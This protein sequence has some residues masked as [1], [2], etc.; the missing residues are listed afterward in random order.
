M[1]RKFL[2]QRLSAGADY[3]RP[4]SMSVTSLDLDRLPEIPCWDFPDTDT[5]ESVLVLPNTRRRISGA[6]GGTIKLKKRLS[7]VPEL[8]LHDLDQLRR[9]TD[10]STDRGPEDRLADQENPTRKPVNE[11]QLQNSQRIYVRQRPPLVSNRTRPRPPNHN[12]MAHVSSPLS[13]PPIVNQNVSVNAFPIITTDR[14]SK[15]VGTR[16][17]HSRQKSDGE[18]LFDEIL[19]AYCNLPEK[20][21]PASSAIRRELEQSI[22]R[23]F[24]SNGSLRAFKS[25]K[26]MSQNGH[27]DPIIRSKEAMSHPQK[28]E[29]STPVGS[30]V[31][32]EAIPGPE[33][34]NSSGSDP[35]SSGEE[36]SDLGSIMD[37]LRSPQSTRSN[38]EA[39]IYYSADDHMSSPRSISPQQ[40]LARRYSLRQIRSSK[41]IPH[42]LAFEDFVGGSEDDDDNISQLQD[43]LADLDVMD[44]SSSIYED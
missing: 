1:P 18:M 36:F 25:S 42:K 43:E 11:E 44:V 40:N 33:Y 12:S 13:A 2:G 35:S 7:S 22:G 17:L 24:D 8:L 19:K 23:H 31:L 15:Q 4:A 27:F 30:A 6:F 41:V 20:N 10:T 32:E 38:E 5:E 9:K 16:P 28:E 39:D 26:K 21:K 3:V 29:F 37:S 34:T 14:N